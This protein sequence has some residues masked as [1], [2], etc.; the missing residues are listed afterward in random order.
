MMPPRIDRAPCQ[1]FPKFGFETIAR[2]EFPPTVQQ[3]VEVTSA[4][5]STTT[6]M[7]KRL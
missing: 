7:W 5:P 6:V 2:A 4:C 3:S 1:N